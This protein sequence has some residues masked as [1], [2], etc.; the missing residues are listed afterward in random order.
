[1]RLSLSG[2]VWNYLWCF[3]SLF[4]QQFGAGQVAG[5]GIRSGTHI[6]RLQGLLGVNTP[7]HV[8]QTESATRLIWFWAQFVYDRKS[9][10]TLLSHK[11]KFTRSKVICVWICRSGYKRKKNKHV[12]S[13][14]VDE[15][16]V[17]PVLI[18]GQGEY[19]D[20]F[21]DRRRHR[22]VFDSSSSHS[23]C[24]THWPLQLTVWHLFNFFSLLQNFAKEL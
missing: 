9:A 22:W 13:S 19:L 12:F 16:P 3:R 21:Y 14:R 18:S 1:M 11:S 20:P 7:F 17:S 24:C 15:Y 4:G 6:A 2:I 8:T 10:A 5:D 23:G